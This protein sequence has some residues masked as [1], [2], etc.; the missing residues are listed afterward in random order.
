MKSNAGQL[1]L[2]SVVIKQG[3]CDPI[4]RCL[5]SKQNKCDVCLW[6]LPI[7]RNCSKVLTI[8]QVLFNVYIKNMLIFNGKIIVL[9]VISMSS[10]I[11]FFS[12]SKICTEIFQ[13]R[14][15]ITVYVRVFYKSPA[16]Q[17]TMKA[18]HPCLSIILDRFVADS[19]STHCFQYKRLG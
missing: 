2:C 12:L 14:S 8:A 19:W 11:I 15:N 6:A 17:A 18:P 7:G 1:G 9:F 5:Q 16:M 3:M 10:S 4:N 13:D